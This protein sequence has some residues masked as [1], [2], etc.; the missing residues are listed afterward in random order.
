[1]ILAYN[2][3]AIFFG[4]ILIAFF[5][6]WNDKVII[7]FKDVHKVL[8]VLFH[9]VFSLEWIV[10]ASIRHKDVH[11]VLLVLFIQ[12]RIMALLWLVCM[13]D[14]KRREYMDARISVRFFMVLLYYCVLVFCLWSYMELVFWRIRSVGWIIRLYLRFGLVSL[15]L[16]D[17][18]YVR[19]GLFWS[20]YTVW[21][22]LV[23]E[24]C[25]VFGI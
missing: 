9:F 17:Q 5:L 1:M 19:D 8:L 16:V 6:G 23:L 12:T 21:L 14:T 11:K 15:C 24:V 3:L 25:T 22:I 4:M 10:I 7:R 13:A 18:V 2:P 20:I